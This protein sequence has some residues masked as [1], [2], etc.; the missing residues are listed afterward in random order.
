MQQR[1][2]QEVRGLYLNTCCVMQFLEMGNGLRK[3]KECS[4][5]LWETINFVWML[6]L[7]VY[8]WNGWFISALIENNI[9]QRG[10]WQAG[11]ITNLEQCVRYFCCLIWSWCTDLKESS[12]FP[13]PSTVLSLK[14]VR[15]WM[16]RFRLLYQPKQR[17]VSMLWPSMCK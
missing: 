6:V 12:E 10:G 1:R 2:R 16:L 14:S 4:L 5:S 3:R 11:D 17:H 7:H 15:T 13:L 8:F 9:C